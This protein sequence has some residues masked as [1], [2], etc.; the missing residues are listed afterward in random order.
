MTEATDMTKKKTTRTRAEAKRLMWEYYRDNKKTLPK[1]IRE[2][3]EEIIQS[4]Q[5]G[6]L[7]THAFSDAIDIPA[8]S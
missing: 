5:A 4:I 8:S 1:W 7:P 2:C 6:E 3:R